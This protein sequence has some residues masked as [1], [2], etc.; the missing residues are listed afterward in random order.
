MNI[1]DASAT[2]MAECFAETADLTPFAAVPNQQALDELGP[3]TKKITEPQLRK[4]AA[5]SAKLP[6]A[7]ADRCPEDVL[8]HILWRAMK[9]PRA[10]Y[11][12]WAVTKVADDD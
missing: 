8:N 6:L 12:A 5:V 10:P 9:G 2:P 7:E 3:E 1:M 11:P 4:D